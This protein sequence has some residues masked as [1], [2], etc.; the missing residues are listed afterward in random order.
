MA[1][2]GFALSRLSQ[3]GQ[4]QAS[5]TDSTHTKHSKNVE[6]DELAKPYKQSDEQLIEE[7]NRRLPQT[8]CAQCDYPGCRPYAEAII[9]SN[10]AI[11]RCPPGGQALIEELADLLGTQA[12]ALDSNKE[13]TKPAQIAFIV[14]P[15]CIGCALCLPACPVDAIVGAPRFMHT[16]ITEQCTGCEL[17]LPPCPVD[18]IELHTVEQPLHRWQWPRPEL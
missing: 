4:S 14:E 16:V 15:D 11:N 1:G 12:I 10:V 5:S 13:K 7:I 8:Q 2:V 17:C 9:K 6:T 18:C 3:S